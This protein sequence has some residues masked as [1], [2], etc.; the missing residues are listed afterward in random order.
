MPTNPP[1]ASDATPT[2]DPDCPDCGGEGSTMEETGRYLPTG[3]AE[4]EEVPCHCVP[5]PGAG[6]AGDVDVEAI[7]GNAQCVFG[8]VAQGHIPTIEAMLAK[9][10]TWDEIGKAIGWCGDAACEHYIRHLQR[11]RD[12]LRMERDVAR[13]ML[14]DEVTTSRDGYNEVAAERDALRAG[15]DLL[16]RA[17]FQHVPDPHWSKLDKDWRKAR[18]ARDYGA[19]SQIG[20]ELAALARG[21]A[22]GEATDGGGKD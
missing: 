11:E 19:K 18:D 21:P 16:V 22:A 9:W 12:A 13:E 15:L 10:N 5:T 2:P 4:C 17:V 8:L 1:P 20:H 14:R 6:G 3:D 7:L